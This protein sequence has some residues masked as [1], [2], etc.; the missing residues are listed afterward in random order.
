MKTCNCYSG[1]NAELRR[2]ITCST[3][4]I[5]LKTDKIS[6][7]LYGS[8]FYQIKCF[9]SRFK[10]VIINYVLHCISNSVV[11]I[12]LKLQLK[13]MGQNQIFAKLI[14]LVNKNPINVTVLPVEN[15]MFQLVYLNVLAGISN[16]NAVSV[17]LFPVC[18]KAITVYRSTAEQVILCSCVVW[19]L[20]SNS[21]V[22]DYSKR[23]ANSLRAVVKRA[24]WPVNGCDFRSLLPL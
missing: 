18:W 4:K 10:C 16:I 14:A 1:R 13:V 8:C 5:P 23:H 24:I 15:E 3:D 20:L 11:E 12:T 21:S 7:L 9:F 6:K 2:E 22:T 17:G 19:Q